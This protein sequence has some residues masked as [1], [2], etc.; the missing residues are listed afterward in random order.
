MRFGCVSK[1]SKR[2]GGMIFIK[3]TLSDPSIMGK[4][5]KYF[6]IVMEGALIR[7]ISKLAA[8]D[9]S[10]CRPGDFFSFDILSMPSLLARSA[11]AAHGTRHGLNMARLEYKSDCKWMGRHQGALLVYPVTFLLIKCHSEM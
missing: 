7:P 1:V 5:K 3:V 4:K 8:C 11:P 2:F 9:L 10:A 6:L